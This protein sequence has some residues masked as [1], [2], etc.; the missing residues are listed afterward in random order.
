M[1]NL[2]YPAFACIGER[3]GLVAE[4][5]ALKQGL[6]DSTAIDCHI[7]ALAAPAMVVKAAR[8]QLFARASLTENKDVGGSICQAEYLAAQGLDG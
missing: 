1:L 7:V 8:H 3:P 4:D 2:A 6:G 5:L